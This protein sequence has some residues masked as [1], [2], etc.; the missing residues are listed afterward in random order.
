MELMYNLIPLLNVMFFKVWKPSSGIVKE[1]SEIDNIDLSVFANLC[2]CLKHKVGF[3]V[4][5]TRS[6]AVTLSV[7]IV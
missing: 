7:N 5:Y 1:S 6:Y 4:S 2:K 3:L